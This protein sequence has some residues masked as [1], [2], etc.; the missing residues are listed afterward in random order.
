MPINTDLLKK[1]MEQRGIT[2]KRVA[3]ELH[4]DE[5]TYYRKMACNGMTFS[6][7]QVQILTKL[8]ELSKEDASNIFL[9]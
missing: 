8:L 2:A 9:P 7:G 1:R 5:S 3:Q 6:V 4:I